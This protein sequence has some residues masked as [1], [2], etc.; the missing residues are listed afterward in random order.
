MHIYICRG[1][2]LGRKIGLPLVDDKKIGPPFLAPDVF[3]QL[4]H[5]SPG[6]CT[7][8]SSVISSKKK[9]ITYRVSYHVRHV[10]NNPNYLNTYRV[11]FTAKFR[12]KLDACTLP[13]S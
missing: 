6:L 1:E 4:E 10:V 2:I 13:F 11:S 12:Q 7:Y 5:K 8:I 9:K 3:F